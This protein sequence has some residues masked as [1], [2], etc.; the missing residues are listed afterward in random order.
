M[1]R[2]CEGGGIAVAVACVA[3]EAAEVA[4]S[5]WLKIARDCGDESCENW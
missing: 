1:T 5:G 2:G 4:D 3:V